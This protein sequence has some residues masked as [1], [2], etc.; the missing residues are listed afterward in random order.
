MSISEVRRKYN[1]K[2][3]K[4]ALEELQELQLIVEKDG[5]THF[6]FGLMRSKIRGIPDSELSDILGVK[7]GTLQHQRMDLRKFLK[8]KASKNLQRFMGGYS[9]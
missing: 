6:N 9:K 7:I 1:N 2:C 8:P 4:L 3:R 5:V